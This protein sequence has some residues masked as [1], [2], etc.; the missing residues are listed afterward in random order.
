[1]R[2]RDDAAA[3]EDAHEQLVAILANELCQPL[4][5]IRDAAALL[6]Q[7]TLDERTLVSR[8]RSSS[9]GRV[10]CIA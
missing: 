6:R 7:D 5:P 4:A 1:M 2:L 3:C 9:A 8:P 10:T